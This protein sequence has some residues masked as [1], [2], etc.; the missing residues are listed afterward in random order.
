MPQLRR[1]DGRPEP[2]SIDQ[3]IKDAIDAEELE[4]LPGWGRPIDLEDYFSSGPD[5]RAANKLLKDNR[6]LP[7]SL[8]DRKDAEQLSLTAEK[9]LAQADNLLMQR[10][11]TIDRAATAFAAL[12]RD[13]AEANAILAPCSWPAFSPAPCALAPPTLDQALA[14]GQTL[15]PAL[16]GYNRQIEILLSQNLHLL[17]RAN[18]CINR[19]NGQVMFSRDLPG[20]LQMHTHDLEAVAA[21]LKQNYAL[22]DPLPDDLDQR[23]LAY[24]KSV[25]PS[26]WR[27]L[28]MR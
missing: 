25:R 14:V 20:G 2:R 1:A 8:Q 26:A 24:A 13:H 18:E 16:R 6:V 11:V 27:R 17:G 10:R 21:K 19:L 3:I 23:L 5:Q 15:G 4:K 12:F 22:L 7:Q 28:V 9:Q